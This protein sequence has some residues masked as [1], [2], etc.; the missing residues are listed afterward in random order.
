MTLT[1]SRR[2]FL[3]RAG[4]IAATGVATPMALN[5]AAMANA[6]AASAQ[7]YK[8]LVCVY[9][10]GGNDHA[11]TLI[12][13][14]SDSHESYR[15]Q[16]PGLL[17]GLDK[18]Q[19]TLLPTKLPGGRQYA[20]AP[21]LDKLLP[22]Y[23]KGQLA[24]MLNIGTLVEP[25]TL[26]QVKSGAGRL[27]PK[28]GSHNDQRAYFQSSLPEGGTTGWGGRMADEYVVEGDPKA[29]FTCVGVDGGG[30]FLSGDS[31]IAY[32]VSSSGA[33]VVNAAKPG[34]Q[35]F[36]S[37]A[38]RDAFEQ[39]ITTPRS[40]LFANEYANTVKRSIDT[41]RLLSPI[42]KA[43]PAGSFS[44]NSLSRQLAMV[45][46]MIAAR[47]ALG[48]K[49]QVFYVSL[50][51]FD[52]HNDL[53]MN[54]PRLL[55]YVGAALSEFQTQLGIL[56]VADQVTTFT[57]SDFGRTINQNDDGSDHA[58]GSMH[59]V[60]GGAGSVNGKKYYG[61]APTLGTNSLVDL[62]RGRLMPTRSTDQ[63]SYTLGTWFGLSNSQLESI[64]PNIKNFS[65]DDRN[66]KFMKTV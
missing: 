50:G 62:G 12:P 26:D 52:M 37:S 29:I 18:L 2:E 34:S 14:D 23:N 54:H 20:L 49:R 6:A 35:L 58:W 44:G 13:Y 43:N 46:R 48:P 25:V 63:L 4:A 57:A 55:G 24:V 21:E 64:L 42:L 33:L 16:R 22:L 60:L 11:N 38:C 7:D 56:G 32:Q 51:G 9:L 47:D 41:E 39:L 5:L 19:G 31:S 27:P 30:V 1:S 8:A 10:D 61:D 53:L 17:P 65:T 36:G 3:K 66:M 28:L 45:A 40:N 15:L 59:F